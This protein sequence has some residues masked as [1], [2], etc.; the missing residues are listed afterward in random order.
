[1]TDLCRM[2]VELCRINVELCRINVGFMSNEAHIKKA[3]PAD[4]HIVSRRPMSNV[5]QNLGKRKYEQQI[6]DFKVFGYYALEIP[7]FIAY[8][9]LSERWNWDR[10]TVMIF[11]QSLQKMGVI[12]VK[13]EYR[14]VTVHILNLAIAPLNSISEINENST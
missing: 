3:Q 6:K 1:M 11:L 2:N 14:R 7:F 5:E 13:R 10:K 8:Q 9:D 4:I 12:E